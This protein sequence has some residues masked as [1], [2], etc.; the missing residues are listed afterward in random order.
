MRLKLLAAIEDLHH[1]EG[2]SKDTGLTVNHTC[3]IDA[4]NLTLL[5][6]TQ[7]ARWCIQPACSSYITVIIGFLIGRVLEYQGMPSSA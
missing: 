4:D 7:H 2:A 6:F 1:S 3:K 5:C